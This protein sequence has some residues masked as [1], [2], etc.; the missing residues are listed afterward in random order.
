M[1]F[2]KQHQDKQPRKKAIKIAQIAVITFLAIFFLEIWVVNRLSTYGNKI[3]ELKNAKAAL[4]LE[5]QILSNAIAKE[6][7]L[8]SVEKKAAVIGFA[9][10]KNYTYLSSPELASVR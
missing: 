7:S 6:T 2:L 9:S 8:T 5:N 1:K 4:E 3:Q 10:V